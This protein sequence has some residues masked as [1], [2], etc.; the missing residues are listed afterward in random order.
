MYR[1]NVGMILGIALVDIAVVGE[2]VGIELGKL[3]CDSLKNNYRVVSMVD[4]MAPR[5]EKTSIT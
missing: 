4:T 1:L 5:E 3:H 2:G